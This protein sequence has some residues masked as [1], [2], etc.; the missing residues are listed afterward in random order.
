MATQVLTE[1]VKFQDKNNFV[2]HFKVSTSNPRDFKIG[3]HYIVIGQS[4]KPQ[5]VDSDYRAKKLNES[6]VS[7]DSI[8]RCYE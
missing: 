6:I 5:V 1:T 3:D 7:G 8:R 2:R 4:T